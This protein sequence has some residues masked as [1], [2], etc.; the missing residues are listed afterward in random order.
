MV[1][2]IIYVSLGQDGFE[3]SLFLLD[4]FALILEDHIAFELLDINLDTQYFENIILFGVSV[5]NE[6]SGAENFG[7]RIE[8]T[9]KTEVGYGWLVS[10]DNIEA[11]RIAIDSENF[12]LVVGFKIVVN[13]EENLFIIDTGS[14]FRTLNA[15]NVRGFIVVG[16]FDIISFLDELGEISKRG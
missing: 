16:D 1:H 6:Q 4:L 9:D 7:D 2:V 10:L 13:L 8:R 15:E 5:A 3:N 12:T 14:L 11:A